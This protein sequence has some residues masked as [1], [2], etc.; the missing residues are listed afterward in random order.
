MNSGICVYV[1][2]LYIYIL[3]NLH[4]ILLLIDYQVVTNVKSKIHFLHPLQKSS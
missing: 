1:L 4:S 3:N 2:L